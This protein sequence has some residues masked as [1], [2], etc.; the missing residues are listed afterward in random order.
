MPMHVHFQLL[1]TFGKFKNFFFMVTKFSLSEFFV[2]IKKFLSEFYF[3][4]L[5]EKANE[6]LTNG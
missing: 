5:R 6:W 1:E 3:L 2:T 4:P